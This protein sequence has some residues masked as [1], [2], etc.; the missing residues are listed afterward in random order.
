MYVCP[1]VCVSVSDY[2]RF[3][4]LSLFWLE[5]GFTMLSVP[6]LE[7]L[8]TVFVRHREGGREQKQLSRLAQRLGEDDHVGWPVK[9]CV[10]FFF[11]IR[12]VQADWF[13]TGDR[14]FWFTGRECGD[15]RSLR[16]LCRICVEGTS[17]LSGWFGRAFCVCVSFAGCN[18]VAMS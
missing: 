6:A 15:T 16:I 3:L 9:F 18:R 5:I 7:P 17:G 13:R 4:V 10:L 8:A 2:A 14:F 12:F 11:V 1:C